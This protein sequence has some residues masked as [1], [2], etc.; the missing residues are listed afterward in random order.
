MRASSGIADTELVHLAQL[1]QRYRSPPIIR[2]LASLAFSDK[3]E[4][5]IEE[6]NNFLVASFELAFF[7]VEYQEWINKEPRIREQNWIKPII[8]RR[9]GNRKSL[10]KQHFIDPQRG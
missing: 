9:N 5:M 7:V 6:P 4:D 1:Q 3:P 8:V 10:G 2:R